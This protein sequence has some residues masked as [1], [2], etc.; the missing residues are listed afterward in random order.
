M[1]RYAL[2]RRP[3]P[4]AAQGLT[5]QVGPPL[6]FDLLEQQHAA[7]CRALADL[8][9]HLI[10]LDPLAGFPDAYFVEDAA[11]VT[12]E[13]AVI[14]NSGA[15]A[16]RGEEQSIAAVLRC[17]RGLKTIQPPGTLDGGD[18]MVVDRHVF[19]GLSQRT[20]RSAADQLA[21]LLTPF[22]YR[23]TMVSVDDG[24]H[25]KTSVNTIG[26]DLLLMVASW[27]QR[28]EFAGYRLLRVAPEESHACNTICINGHLI[29]P[30][31]FPQTRAL[32]EATG[33]PIITLDTS[34][35]RRMDGGLSCLSL[36]F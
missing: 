31:G 35:F 19:V 23:L 26:D 33:L 8:G 29:T 18:V 2:V 21:R 14:A 13:M 3:G 36:R 9:I 24:L 27:S 1:I 7:Y 11:V 22:G 12:P 4:E 16:R 5:T 25:L 32:L 28:P 34:Q 30:A 17:H 20:N 6:Q 15:R 10:Q